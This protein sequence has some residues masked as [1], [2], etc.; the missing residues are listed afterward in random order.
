[1]KILA[2]IPGGLKLLNSLKYMNK[3]K[4]II[5]DAVLSGDAERER[6]YIL[7]STSVWGKMVFDM[8]G[9]SLT[10][11]GKENLPQHG[12]VVFIGNHQ[13]YAD[14]IAYCAAMTNFQFGFVAK[15]EL[16][17]I[18]FFGKWIARIRSVFIERD[19]PRASLKAIKKGIEYISEG[20]SLVIFPE[21]TRSKGPDPG[22]F[23][24]GSTK[25]ATKPGV[26]IVPV[27]LQ[28]TY[29]MFEE[30]GCIRGTDISIMIHEPIETAGMSREDEKFLSDR[31]EKIVVDGVRELQE[32]EKSKQ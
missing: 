26:P 28:G 2:N 23:M 29:R 12:P 8:F 16:S 24:K 9:S 14:I 31:V 18:P 10:V 4:K 21:G 1:M 17:K 15:E 5:E 13:G 32:R 7:K 22:P 27:S 19:D 20:Y 25:L 11:Y 30:E 3:N 6:E